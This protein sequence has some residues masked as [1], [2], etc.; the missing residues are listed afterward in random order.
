MKVLLLNVFL[1]LQMEAYAA[2]LKELETLLSDVDRGMT[3]AN[4]AEMEVALSATERLVKDLQEDTEQLAGTHLSPSLIDSLSV[5][6]AGKQV[7][8]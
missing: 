4:N 8:V 3:P 5:T 6:G 1:M 7:S 2:R